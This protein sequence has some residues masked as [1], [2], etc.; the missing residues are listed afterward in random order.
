MDHDD[1]RLDPELL[2]GGAHRNVLDRYRYW[3]LPA[4]RAGPGG[5]RHPLR[6]A[7]QDWEPGSNIGSTGGTPQPF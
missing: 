1:P 5:R 3:R 2:P 4:I 7:L 6:G